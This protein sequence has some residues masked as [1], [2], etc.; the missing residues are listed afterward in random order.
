MLPA[1]RTPTS[2]DLEAA[3]TP[4]FL[5][6]W[7]QLVGLPLRGGEFAPPATASYAR[8]YVPIHG[9]WQGMVVLACSESLAIAAGTT[10]LDY[11]RPANPA[12]VA[13]DV[14]GEL[15]NVLAGQL[16]QVITGS[17]WIGATP[18]SAIESTFK[19]TF[20]GHRLVARTAFLRDDGLVI[21][22]LFESQ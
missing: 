14:T 21:A 16:L 10:M 20:S 9:A 7:K 5:K 22:S 4:T 13:I 6:V 2:T 19:P 8:A 3:F 18:T 11:D 1:Q 17:S 15:A 12:V